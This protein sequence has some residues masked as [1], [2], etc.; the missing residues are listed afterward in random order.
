MPMPRKARPFGTGF[1]VMNP[2]GSVKTS[3]ARALEAGRGG[4]QPDG[5]YESEFRKEFPTPCMLSLLHV[6]SSP[7]F[8]CCLVHDSVNYSVSPIPY[9]H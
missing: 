1:S 6:F 3:V 8:P 2:T 9:L 4:D 7:N 5:D